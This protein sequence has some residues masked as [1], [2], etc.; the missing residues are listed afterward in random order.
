VV[1]EAARRNVEATRQL[2]ITVEAGN[3][4][5]LLKQ[6]RGLRKRVKTSRIKPRRYQIITGS[7]RRTLCQHWGLHFN[8]TQL[9][10]IVA[11][12]LCDPVPV[13]QA[14]EHDRAAQV[15]KAVFQA[16]LFRN[17]GIIQDFKRRSLRE[18]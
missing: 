6:L 15:Q 16:K 14:V 3:H 4:E 13:P 18:I 10:E 1:P 17:I 5:D 8:E 7:L 9:I 2:E 12:D 11:H